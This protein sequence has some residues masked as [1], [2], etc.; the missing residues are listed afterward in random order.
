MLLDLARADRVQGAL[1][2]EP[3]DTRSQAPMRAFDKLNRCFGRDTIRYAAPGVARGWTMQRGS[4]AWSRSGG[5][6]RSRTCRR[7]SMRRGIGRRQTDV[8]HRL[9]GA[10]RHRAG[11]RFLRMDRREGCEAAAPSRRGRWISLLAFAGLWDRW[12]DPLAGEWIL[13]CT[14]IV[15]G[16]R[17]GWSPITTACRSCSRRKISMQWLDGSLGVDGPKPAPEEALRECESI[18][19]A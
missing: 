2:D 9:Q 15:S 12:K 4:G 16:P 19:A 7:R 17:P 6:N 11:E 13:S 1:F 8:L 3:D 10:A 5:G 18:A 14:I